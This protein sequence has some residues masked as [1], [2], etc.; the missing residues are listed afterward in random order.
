MIENTKLIAEKNKS[1]FNDYTVK[2]ASTVGNWDIYSVMKTDSDVGFP[3]IAV[4]KKTGEVQKGND[5]LEYKIAQQEGL[6][7]ASKQSE[8]STV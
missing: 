5:S 7:K 1:P 8:Q 6:L 2:F 4:N 3:M